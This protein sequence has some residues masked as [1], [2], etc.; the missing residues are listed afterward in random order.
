MISI[1]FASRNY[2]IM[3]RA[4]QAFIVASVI[5]AIGAA[6]LLG[7]AVSL[8]AES[9][10]M[11]QNLKEAESADK[12]VK[13]VLEEREQ[14]ARDLNAM[15]GL[16]DARKFSWARLLS[17][18]ETVVPVGVA[19]KKVEFNPRD[20]TLAL[21]GMAQSPE[22]LRDL[23]VGLEKSA[24]FKD[25]FLKHQSLEKGA[26]RSMWSLFIMNIKA[27]AWLRANN[28]R[29][30]RAALMFTGLLALDLLLFGVLVAPS[31]ARLA[32]WD[33]EYDALRK[34]HAEAV[35]FMKQKPSFAG[36]MA[37]IPAQKD[38]PLLVKDLVLTARRL[39]LTVASVKYDIPR[40]TSGELALLTFS[41]PA[42]G[43]YPDIKRFIYEVET[44]DRLVGIQE[45]KMDSGQGRVKLEMK[46]VTYIKRQ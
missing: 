45:L 34:R 43:A 32:T 3:A 35:L 8:R 22:S 5:L 29:L 9:T 21:D 33:S 14:L 23:V 4:A 28:K 11:Q 36:I 37:G 27:P 30:R 42:E 26:F 46:L 31:T 25:P 44:S 39:N 6:G 41:F 13:S 12:Q 2:R 15:S 17:S 40:R 20:N 1:N 10:V 7:K 38:M 19:L 16:M 18:I 24:S